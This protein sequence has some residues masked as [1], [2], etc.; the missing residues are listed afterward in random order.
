MHCSID[1][2][3]NGQTG[4]LTLMTRRMQSVE[5]IYRNEK[6]YRCA[7]APTDTRHEKSIYDIGENDANAPSY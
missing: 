1:E 3:N 7:G 4:R 6:H 2:Q 5:C